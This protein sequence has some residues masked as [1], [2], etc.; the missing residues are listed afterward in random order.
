MYTKNDDDFR[1]D[2]HYCFCQ[3]LM[4]ESMEARLMAKIGG[5]AHTLWN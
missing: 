1:T 5:L 2:L 3:R 4:I